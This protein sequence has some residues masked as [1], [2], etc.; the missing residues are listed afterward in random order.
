M[1]RTHAVIRQSA[2][3]GKIAQSAHPVI[4]AVRNALFRAM[5]ERVQYRQIKQLYKT[6][7][8]NPCYKK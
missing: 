2:R 3:I 8:K 5:P 1:S 4:I 6:D 7:F